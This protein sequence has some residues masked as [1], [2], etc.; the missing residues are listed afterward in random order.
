M[1]PLANQIRPQNLIDI[2][3]QEHL[4]DKG[5]PL[6]QMVLK[7]TLQSSILW[8]PTGT[9]KTSIVRA[10]AAN[11][12][13]TFCQLNA[14]KATVKDLRTIIL[15]AE[16]DISEGKR[17]IV[18][19]DEIHRWN[20]S[21]QD[22]MLPVV[23]DG[24]II[25]FGAT[26]EQPKF[27]VNSTILSRCLVLEVKPLEAA[28]LVKVIKRVKDHY[29]AKGRTIEIDRNA[30]KVLINRCSGDA[31]KLITVLETCI[32]ILSDDDKINEKHIN[33]AMPDKHIAFDASGND[34]FDLAH[35]Y[36]ESIQHSDGDAA[37]YWLAKWI[38]SGED[39]AYICRRMLITAFEDCA[40]NP[41]A[42]LLAMAASYT[43]ERTGL[44]E[45]KIAMALATIVMAKSERN[46]TAYNA[47]NEATADIKNNVTIHV[48]PQLRAGS[49]G[50][51]SAI[52][53]KYITKWD[54][55]FWN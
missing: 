27:A 47:I 52:N 11:T 14:T 54:P 38:E 39:P 35:C 15:S 24:T 8:G 46:K 12:N 55:S 50:Y 25:L 44:P 22:T 9:G 4:T 31:R 10:L 17:T 13:S 20:K 18:F 7:D 5:M 53:K 23:E 2:I 1:T 36:Q 26:T 33:L 34:H 51:M 30:A 21:Q 42:P 49:K 32:E 29:K 48:P 43:V 45:C 19:V 37:I 16:K 3:G 28:A 6:N 40:N 41:L